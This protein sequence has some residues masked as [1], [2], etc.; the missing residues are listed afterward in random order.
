MERAIFYQA[1]NPHK[2]VKDRDFC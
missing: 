1:L 2:P